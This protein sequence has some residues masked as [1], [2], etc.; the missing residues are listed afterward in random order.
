MIHNNMNKHQIEK[1]NDGDK[2][3]LERYLDKHNLIAY[4]INN[5]FL[6]IYTSFEH[7]KHI[8]TYIVS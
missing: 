2:H 8:L 4:K 3:N 6:E 1:S 5:L 7:S